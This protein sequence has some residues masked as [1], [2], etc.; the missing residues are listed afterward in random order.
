MDL[1]PSGQDY[2]IIAVFSI[3][4][5]AISSPLIQLQNTLK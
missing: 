4:D 1:K 3:I 2:Q 5:F